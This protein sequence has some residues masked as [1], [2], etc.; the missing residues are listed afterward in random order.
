MDSNPEDSPE[1]WDSSGKLAL[2]LF[3][4]AGVEFEIIN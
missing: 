4:E 2:E 1:P 3:K